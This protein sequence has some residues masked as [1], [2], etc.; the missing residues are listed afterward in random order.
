MVAVGLGGNDGCATGAGDTTD[1]CFNSR[2]FASMRAILDSV[3]SGGGVQR[4]GEQG[5]ESTHR[6]ARPVDALFNKL[7]VVGFPASLITLL[8][9]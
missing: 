9:L 6:L 1:D 7:S 2:S 5:T 4:R 3:L 8:G